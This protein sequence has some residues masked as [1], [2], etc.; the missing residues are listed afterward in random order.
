MNTEARIK[1][2]EAEIKAIQDKLDKGGTIYYKVLYQTKL[3]GKQELINDLKKI[4]THE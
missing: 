1:E 4:L 3:E 2:I